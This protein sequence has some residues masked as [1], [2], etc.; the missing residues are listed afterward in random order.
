MMKIKVYTTNYWFAKNIPYIAECVSKSNA[1]P[2]F[3]IEEIDLPKLPI[4]DGAPDWS[5]LRA[6]LF[7]AGYNAVCLHISHKE[8]DQLGLSSSLGGLYHLDSD[9]VLDFLVIADKRSKATG[10]SFNDFTR[11]FLHELAHGFDQWT[12]GYPN[13]NVHQWDYEHKNIHNIF[14]LYNYDRMSI[15]R[16]LRMVL[17]EV[18][19][20]LWRSK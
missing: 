15:T 16:T 12:F 7:E 20:R 6:N 18:I 8:R 11:I 14:A 19:R 2:K 5:W 17:L 10:Y 3:E 1:T 4:V 13:V 9:N